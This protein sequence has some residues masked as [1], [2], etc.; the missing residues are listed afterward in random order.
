MRQSTKQQIIIPLGTDETSEWGNSFM[1]V[2][3]PVGK[4]SYSLDL[5]QLNQALIRP[6]NKGPT[7]NAIFPRLTCM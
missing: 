1:L 4:Y 5:S 2:P 6:A 7:V 3:K